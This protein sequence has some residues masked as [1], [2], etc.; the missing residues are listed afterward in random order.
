MDSTFPNQLFPHFY[1][2]GPPEVKPK[3]SYGG[4]GSY[5]RVFAVSADPCDGDQSW[6]QHVFES[7]HTRSGEEWVPVKP[8]VTP[9]IPPCEDAKVSS[10]VLPDPMDFPEHM[11]YFY[12]HHCMDAFST[13]GHLLQDNLSFKKKQPQDVMSMRWASNFIEG[14]K[15]KR[16]E[17]AF[18][19]R[20]IR[21]L[22]HIV[23]D[24]VSDVPPSLLASLLHE[25]LTSQREQQRFCADAT[26]GALGYVP[27]HESPEYSDGCLIYPSGDAMDKLNF[28]R[29]VQQF[30]DDKPPS[31]V[32]DSQPFVCYLNGTVR[33]IS[34]ANMEDVG[35]VA[36]RSD[37]FCAVWLLGDKTKPLLI[38]VIQTKDRFS[39]ITVSPHIP[40]ELAVVNERGAAYLWTAKKG[41]QKFREEDS[42]LYF[43]AKSPWRWCE[44]SGHPRVMVY[45]DRTGAELTDIRSADSNHTLFR[46]GRTAACMSGERVILAKYL[47]KSH[48]HHHLINTQFSTYI[49]D[50]RVPSVPMLKWDH[51]MESP[52]MF[53][54]DL[55][56]QT[57]SQ[58]CKLLLGAQRS[59]ELMLLQYT[60]GREHVCQTRGSIQKLS[61]P[62]ES[63]S[64]LNLLL[65]HKRHLAQKRLNVPAAGFTA[66]QKKDYLSVFQ[67]TETGDIFY[68]ALK[69]HTDQTASNNGA[70]EQSVS[71]QP[72]VETGE[73][74]NMQSDND[75]QSV[76]SDSETEGR[77]AALRHLEVIDNVDN[78]DL[79]ALDTNENI[80][81]EPSSHSIGNNPTCP[82]R[83]PNPSKDPDLQAAWNKWFKPIFKKAETKKRHHKFRR[84]RTDHLKGMTGKKLNK[85]K[86]DKF[87]SL[88]KDLQEVMRKKGMLLHGVTYL[89]H[90]NITPVPDPVDADDWPDD[91]SQRLAAS[92][93]GQWT[94]WW[95]EKLGLNQ[96][97]KIAALRRKRR[98]AK[99][100]KSHSRTSLSGSFTSS[101][102]YQESLSGLSSGESQC[103]GLDDETL[104]N[105][106]SQ[107]TDMEEWRARPEIHRKS[108]I[109]LRRFLNEQSTAEKASRSP[110]KSP[111]RPDQNLLTSPSKSQSSIQVEQPTSRTPSVAAGMDLGP[112]ALL[113]STRPTTVQSKKLKEFYLSSLP[114]SQISTL[115]S[116]PDGEY[117]S[118]RVRLSSPT[119]SSHRSL[120]SQRVPQFR[121]LSQASQP[122]KK[123]RMGF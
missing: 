34:S 103:L 121:S 91:V 97:K 32:M 115:D 16:C 67:L 93:E 90:L 8:A 27:L 26:G 83:P 1:L 95:E 105:S 123:S 63:L 120:H 72:T 53:A 80:R 54:C 12:Q 113:P 30:S 21:H 20:K 60:G 99:Q 24:I 73:S 82:T 77:R 58:S 37:Y 28:H 101:V 46:I 45:A 96:D 40:N 70:P 47:S 44:F 104:E 109:I 65:P 29:V 117:S 35:N 87:M 41:L 85:P 76:Q 19:S 6:V 62:K 3:H 119:P 108:P 31:F 114:T 55:P 9:L 43:N 7:Q 81:K 71:V 25:E 122:K 79:N 10:G 18:S 94:Y 57:P 59:Q 118:P 33:Q 52:P 74:E 39:C 64:H 110:R 23:G 17:V 89:P 14:L 86:E 69:V 50:E 100:A 4:W 15:Y 92:W 48:A 107:A 11:K 5:E 2:D 36:V 42:N 78:D 116:A 112:P 66:V 51:M 102:S 56:A 106:D 68:Q 38:D 13:M 111:P 49:V 61:S 22:H 88:R 75:E 84:I 98:R